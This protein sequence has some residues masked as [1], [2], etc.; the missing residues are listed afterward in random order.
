LNVYV[1][2]DEGLLYRAQ[3]AIEEPAP[4]S[5]ENQTQ[6]VNFSEYKVKN[7]YLYSRPFLEEYLKALLTKDTLR[8]FICMNM[9]RPR[10]IT[11]CMQL[12]GTKKLKDVRK[13]VAG[14][15]DER[16]FAHPFSTLRDQDP[17]RFEQVDLIKLNDS[18]LNS[19]SSCIIST[20]VSQAT[21][22][23]APITI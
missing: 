3:K 10:L 16:S 9:D 21:V 7:E 11:L 6:V 13:K 1:V 20:S 5:F 2:L 15:C 23:L 18:F 17:S 19:P 22:K 8:V 4:P 14:L 12:F